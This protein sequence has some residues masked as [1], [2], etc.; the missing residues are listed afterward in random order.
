[1]SSSQLCSRRLSSLLFIRVF[2]SSSPQHVIRAY[3]M[4]L[5]GMT[6][7][8]MIFTCFVAMST[9]PI[10]AHPSTIQFLAT[11][12]Y[13]DID[14]LTL[15]PHL[16]TSILIHALP[17]THQSHCTSLSSTRNPPICESDTTDGH[18]GCSDASGRDRSCRRGLYCSEEVQAVPR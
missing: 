3:P 16:H 15:Q 11:D 12:I 8:T 5:T 9:S 13:I 1:M 4:E 17:S 18:T 6:K 2:I 7:M 14:L 10:K